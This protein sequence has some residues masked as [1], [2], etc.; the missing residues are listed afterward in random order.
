MQ[1]KTRYVAVVA[2]SA[3]EDV[4]SVLQGAKRELPDVLQAI[5]YLDQASMDVVRKMNPD[6]VYPFEKDFPHYVLVEIAQT[7]Q[8]EGSESSDF[9]DLEMDRLLAFLE[10]VE[11][12]IE[13]SALAD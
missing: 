7:H 1:P 9:E 11:E 4:L 12:S 8:F 3:F 6:T 13:V 5:E 2:C 10:R